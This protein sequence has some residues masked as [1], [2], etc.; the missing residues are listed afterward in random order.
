MPLLKVINPE[1]VG[2]YLAFYAGAVEGLFPLLKAVLGRSLL[3]EP[4]AMEKVSAYPEQPPA[5][6]TE[7]VFR[8]EG[9]FYRF[10]PDKAD[11]DKRFQREL[12]YVRD[13]LA[14][15]LN[16]GEPWIREKDGQ[17]RIKALANVGTLAHAKNLAD[18]T[19]R[20]AFEKRPQTAKNPVVE[21]SEPRCLEWGRDLVVIEESQ[22]GFRWVR[23]LTPEALDQESAMLNHCAGDGHY[24]KEVLS[25]KTELYSLRD[26]DGQAC[27]TLR[28]RKETAEHC[29]GLND[30]PPAARYLP[31][32]AAFILSQG[33]DV[34]APA[35]EGGLARDDN[36]RAAP[37][38]QAFQCTP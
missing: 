8:T 12:I 13:W 6:L 34:K 5:W 36:G 19:K 35:N 14:D 11:K 32:I 20:R 2:D 30:R 15:A 38:A 4:R 37:A 21:P 29:A 33:W 1:E 3:R 31:M 9:P 24:D 25:G 27:A 23:L 26:P 10:S 18:K 28:V 17:G 7:D 16:N 22:D